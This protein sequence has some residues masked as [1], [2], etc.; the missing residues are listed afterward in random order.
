MRQLSLLFVLSYDIDRMAGC[1]V[2]G[3]SGSVA[4]FLW[5]VVLANAALLVAEGA[6]DRIE[7]RAL[8]LSIVVDIVTSNLTFD[9]RRGGREEIG[10][11]CTRITSTIDVRELQA[12]ITPCSASLRRHCLAATQFSAEKYLARRK[13]RTLACSVRRIQ[14]LCLDFRR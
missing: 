12:E 8:V 3:R 10:V 5:K 11:Y 13:S 14:R 4:L 9:V 6:A 7:R 2:Q 1:I